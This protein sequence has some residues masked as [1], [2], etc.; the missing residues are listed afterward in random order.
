VVFEA[1]EADALD[2]PLTR[3]ARDAELALLKLMKDR[4]GAS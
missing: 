3:D 1:F 2:K 4:Q